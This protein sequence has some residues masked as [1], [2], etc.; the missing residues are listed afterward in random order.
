MIRDE[1]AFISQVR[2]DSYFK[3]M[4][5]KIHSFVHPA[6]NDTGASTSKGRVPA[7]YE[8]YHVGILSIVLRF[9]PVHVL[10]TTWETPGFREFHRRMQLFIVLYI[11]GGSYIHED[12]ETWEFMVL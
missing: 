1:A 7:E 10:Q 4:G 2:E 6:P 8:V 11:E 9:N 5:T 12:E 3:P